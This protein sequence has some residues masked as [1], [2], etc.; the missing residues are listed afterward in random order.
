[1]LSVVYLYL[2][3]DQ[4]RMFGPTIS[5]LILRHIG[6]QRCLLWDSKR[7]GR[8]P[9]TMRILKRVYNYWGAEGLSCTAYTPC[10]RLTRVLGSCLHYLEL[11][12]EFGDYAGLQG[13]GYSRIR[14]VVGL[15][16]CCICYFPA[17]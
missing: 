15:R 16:G 6:P 14:H 4:E 13:S 2:G 5:G 3:L 12:W 11:Q 9:D 7:E 17:A 1:M 10:W 8:R